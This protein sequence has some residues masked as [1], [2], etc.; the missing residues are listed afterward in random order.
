MTETELDTIF[1]VEIWKI[2][3]QYR[4]GQLSISAMSYQGYW[5]R[6]VCSVTHQL[7]EGQVELHQLE[8]GQTGGRKGQGGLEEVCEAGVQQVEG[9]E[10]VQAWECYQDQLDQQH[11]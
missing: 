5:T 1:K 10:E 9:E 2:N 11:Y 8:D 3:L 4:F 7:Q 6:D